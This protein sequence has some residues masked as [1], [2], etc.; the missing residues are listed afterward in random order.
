MIEAGAYAAAFKVNFKNMLAYKMDIVLDLSFTVLSSLIFI[1]VWAAV[2]YSSNTNVISGFSLNG[3][4]A[5]YIVLAAISEV[6]GWPKIINNMEEDMKEGGIAR[7]LIRPMNYTTQLLLESVPVDMVFFAF[8]SLPILIGVVALGHLNIQA[9]AVLFFAVF[10]V[11]AYLM[12][13]IIGFIIGSMAIYL[14]SV[15][16]VANAITWLFGLA[17]GSIVPLMFL[18]QSVANALML[19]PFA[20]MYYI[21]DA[22]LLGLIPAGAAVQ[23]AFIG[24]FWVLVFALLA[25]I[26]WNKAKRDINAV[27]G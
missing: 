27:G 18:P 2:Y 1:F 15:W 5:Y 19:T 8:G 9:S 10:M 4:I 11:I 22:T 17:G 6:T 25:S 16:G 7:F 24:A 26:I 14:T 13:N 20:F 23:S 21:P 3:I 12:I